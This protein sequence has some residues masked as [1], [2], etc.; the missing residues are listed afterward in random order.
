MTS[1][2]ASFPPHRDYGLF[3]PDSVAWKVFSYPSTEF[4]GFQRTVVTEMFEPFLM[5]AVHDTQAVMRR[6]DLRYDRTLQYTSTVVFG[7]SEAV[8]TAAD[9][10]M[11]IHRHIVGTEPISGQSYDANDP[12]SQL[13]IHLTQW[14][15][16]LYAY[17]TFGPGRLTVAED[18]Q[19]WA[20]CAR[21]AEMQTIDPGTVP[22]SRQEMRAYYAR[23]R[24]VLAGTEVAQTTANHLL[25]ASEHLLTNAPLPLRVLRPVLRRVF[26]SGTIATLPR[27]LRRMAGV[28][29]GRVQDAAA[30]VVLRVGLAVLVRSTRLRLFAVRTISPQTLPVVAPILLD[31][32]PADP[33]VVTP[34]QAWAAIGRPTAREQYTEQL[35]ARVGTPTRAPVDPGA[36]HLLTFG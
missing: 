11:R 4:I 21:A 15:S 33:V 9:V 29:Q 6:P 28:R 13:W 19:Y 31:L 8:A 12:A 10:L 17:E 32:P 26:R 16:V 1:D 7:D 23:M 5:A 18:R 24:P 2:T 22:R 34:A 20:E 14:H 36:E 3:G 35:A 25:N 27:W 30:T